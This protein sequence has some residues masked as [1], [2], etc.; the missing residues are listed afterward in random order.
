MAES[1]KVHILDGTHMTTKY[2]LDKYRNIGSWLTHA[3]T[4]TERILYYT[5]KSQDWWS[6]WWSRNYGLDGTRTGEILNYFLQQLVFG[7]I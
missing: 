7:E 2:T 4:T 3:E 1:N 5:V 6:S